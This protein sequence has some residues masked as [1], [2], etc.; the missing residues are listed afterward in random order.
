MDHQKT[1][2]KTK[3]L[4]NLP[5]RSALFRGKTTRKS[6]P[7]PGR[8]IHVFLLLIL[9][10]F[11]EKVHFFLAVPETSDIHTLLE[12]VHFFPE[13]FGFWNSLLSLLSTLPCCS[14]YLAPPHRNRLH[15]SETTSNFNKA[16]NINPPGNKNWNLFH[17]SECVQITGN[18]A[19]ISITKCSKLAFEKKGFAFHGFVS[20]K[21]STVHTGYNAIGYSAKSDI[22]PTLT[23]M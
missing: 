10:P 17:R 14:C 4:I 16:K 22:V 9:H 20:P 5:G 1:V 11:R 18:F 19:V 21:D 13:N 2:P 8:W 23:P 3:I 12:K 7:L 6:A 15:Y